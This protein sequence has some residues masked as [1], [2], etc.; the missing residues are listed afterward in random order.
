MCLM[1][2]FTM[3]LNPQK[4]VGRFTVAKPADFLQT[5]MDWQFCVVGVFFGARHLLF[6]L[7]ST[8]NVNKSFCPWVPR[9]FVCG[10]TPFMMISSHYS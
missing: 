10:L 7:M 1:V 4:S 3:N 8:E 5:I 9:L 2:V 6:H